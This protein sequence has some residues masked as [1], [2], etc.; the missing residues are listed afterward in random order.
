MEVPAFVAAKLDFCQF[1]KPWL[2]SGASIP[3]FC[4]LKKC[5]IFELSEVAKEIIFSV[6]QYKKWK[7]FL[8]FLGNSLFLKI[9]LKSRNFTGNITYN[10]ILPAHCCL[11][12]RF[13]QTQANSRLKILPS[14]EWY[15]TQKRLQALL[16]S[17]TTLHSIFFN[18]EWRHWCFLLNVTNLKNGRKLTVFG[19]WWFFFHI[20]LQK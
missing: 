4:F 14:L 7:S 20:W 3:I 9:P 16:K 8:R 17:S 1:T 18:P 13:S 10:W 2:R 6:Q 5:W 11:K 15:F 19:N 12:M